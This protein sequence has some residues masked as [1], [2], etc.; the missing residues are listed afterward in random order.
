MQDRLDSQLSSFDSLRSILEQLPFGLLLLDPSLSIIS[1]NS[2]LK[3][4][5][6]AS[7]QNAPRLTLESMLDSN[8]EA[9][10]YAL[11]QALE[12]GQPVTLSAKF[13][14]SIFHLEPLPGSPLKDE[15]P[16]FVTVLPAQEQGETVGLAVVVQDVTDRVMAERELRNEIE[17]LTFLHEL[18]VALSTLELDACM[19]VVVTR[20]RQFFNASFAALL[21]LRQGQLELVAAD[22]LE[23]PTS[24]VAVDLSRGITGWVVQNRKPLRVSNTL[25]DSRY[26]PLFESVRSEMAVPLIIHGQCIGAIDLESD[27]PNAFSADDLRLLELAAFS[28]ASALYNAQA[29]QEVDHWRSYY[30]AV[31]NQT[32]DVIYTVDREC[33]ITSVNA[34]WDQFALENHGE[35]WLS[36]VCIGKSLLTALDPSLR[37]KWQTLCDELLHEKRSQYQEEI[38]CHAPGKERWLSLRAAPLKNEHGEVTGI[39]FSTHD[40]TEHVLAE[41][42]LRA[43]N[44]QLETLL[45][46]AQAF[47]QNLPN[48]NLPQVTVEMLAEA[49]QADCVTITRYNEEKQGFTVIAA[50]GASEKHV[51]EFL[52]PCEQA[53]NIIRKFGKTGVIYRLQESVYSINFPIYRQDELHGLLYSIIE[54]QGKMIGSLNVF[55]RDV[56]RRFHSEEIGLIQALTPQIGL[57]MENSRLYRELLSQATTDV[58]TGLA[59]RRQLDDWLAGEIYRSRRYGRV[60]SVLMID[61]DH[62]K[63]YND[64]YGHEMGDLLLKQVASIFKKNLRT[65]DWPARYGGDEFVVILPETDING[66]S[67]IA[68]RLQNAVAEITLPPSNADSCPKIT[69][70]VGIASFPGSAE[71]PSSLLHC[72]DQAL[73]RAKQRGRDR[74]EVYVEG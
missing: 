65:G 29:Y 34:A 18:D 31:V 74:I 32:G 44:H 13:H 4:R 72:A 62:F 66:A 25:R 14:R 53:R 68:R 50:C 59:N 67:C 2:F 8:S 41:R 69:L 7:L 55:T 45:R 28:A 70:S 60:F 15:V 33:K 1:I 23:I 64:T 51:Q 48:Q 46:L 6:P 19:Q 17:K 58:L 36:K 40:I 11:R 37:S 12:L 5:L 35:A 10:L 52:S 42:Q 22:G 3:E 39:V 26:I 30:E 43:V 16:H 38:P 49:L 54:I 47:N 9:T 71:S 27:L 20:L 21:V 56:T 63:C 73:Y 61:L 57:A 24:S